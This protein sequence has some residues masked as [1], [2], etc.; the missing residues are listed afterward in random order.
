M[1]HAIRPIWLIFAVATAMVGHTIHHSLL[2][3][4]MDFIFAPLTWCKWLVCH[5]VNMTI[6]KETFSFFAS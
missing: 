3:S 1:K 5:E 6:I 2:W 4:C